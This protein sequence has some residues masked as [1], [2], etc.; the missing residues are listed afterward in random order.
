MFERFAYRGINQK[1][2]LMFALRKHPDERKWVFFLFL[3]FFFKDS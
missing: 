2:V 1:E 3:T